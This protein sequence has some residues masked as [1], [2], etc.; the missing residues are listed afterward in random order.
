M[1]KLTL[2][3]LMLPIVAIADPGAATQFLIN[4]PV[5][6]MDMGIFR[7]ERDLSGIVE[8]R[9][10]LY[11]KWNDPS[12]TVLD[13]YVS[14]HY[15][16]DLIVLGVEL[17]GVEPK[18][19]ILEEECRVILEQMRIHAR[20]LTEP[21]FRHEGFKRTPEPEDFIEKIKGRT[22]LRCNGNSTYIG[23]DP[24]NPIV[25]VRSMLLEKD[26]VFVTM[27]NDK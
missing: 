10:R 4:D 20:V 26:K 12:L 3:V 1:K 23:D 14:Y 21:W 27:R 18:A 24:L 5:S 15:D 7:A 19:E 9:K 25:S 8:T 22:Q 16:D 13:G 11:K 6:M 17:K 2:L